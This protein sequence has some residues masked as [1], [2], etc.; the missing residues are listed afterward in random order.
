M[1]EKKKYKFIEE[2]EQKYGD[3]TVSVT[4]TVTE[5]GN[6]EKVIEQKKPVSEEKA[7]C[8]MCKYFVELYYDSSKYSCNSVPVRLL[9]D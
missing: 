9:T 6:T 8:Y 2:F 7:N 5:P 1:R 3:R 4:E